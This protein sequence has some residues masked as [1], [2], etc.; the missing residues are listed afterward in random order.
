[1]FVSGASEDVLSVHD[2]WQRKSEF[3]FPIENLSPVTTSLPFSIP[4]IS[5]DTALCGCLTWWH[6]AITDLIIYSFVPPNDEL[7]DHHPVRQ[8]TSYV[9]VYVRVRF[10]GRGL[11]GDINRVVW[12]KKDNYIFFQS[13]SNCNVCSG[14]NKGSLRCWLAPLRGSVSVH[15]EQNSTQLQHVPVA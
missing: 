12:V 7:T 2:M 4:T 3:Y 13:W 15:A 14:P 11:R 5:L 10:G 8:D 6:A 9:I 1:M